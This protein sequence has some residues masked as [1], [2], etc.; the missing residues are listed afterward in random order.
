MFFLFAALIVATA[1]SAVT[2]KTLVGY[3]SFSLWLKILVSSLVIIGWTA[4]LYSRLLRK[5]S[6]WLG[7]AYPYI[8]NSLYILFGF[9]FILFILLVFRDFIWFLGWKISRLWTDSE[10]LNPRNVLYID[11]ANLIVVVLSVFMTIYSVWEGTK[12]PALKT[13]TIETP[14]INQEYRFVLLNDIHITRAISV[15]RIRTIVERTNQLKP[16]AIFLVGD[17]IDD[18]TRY[19]GAQLDELKH[20]KAPLG[21]YAVSGNHEL[22]NGFN[23]WIRNFQRLGIN[24]LINDGVRLKNSKIFVGGIPDLNTA[25]SPY[26]KVNLAK[27]FQKSRHNDYKILLSH[28]PNLKEYP[29][30][31]YDLQLSGHTHGGQIFPFHYLSWQSNKYLAGLYDVD[32]Y[33]LYVSRGT[34]YWGPPMRLFAPSEITEIILKPIKK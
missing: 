9:A 29:D 3:S 4:P 31:K 7:D 14:K 11:K 12:I 20:L 5:A 17:I 8:S 16:D 21:V 18:K 28:Y 33:K 6:S 1:G 23:L 30:R 13:I 32:G 26:F 34:G 2:I 24:I 25:F 19:I 22:Y 10:F 27:T 15:E